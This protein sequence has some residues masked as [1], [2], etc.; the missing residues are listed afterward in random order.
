M[1]LL[2]TG[3]SGRLGHRVVDAFA[4][5]HEIVAFDCVPPKAEPP[6]KV[7]VLTGD[8]RDEPAVIDAAA[9]AEV[10]I[11]LG[12]ISGRARHIP[13]SE[14][15]AINVQGTQH[16]LEAARQAKARMVILASSLCAVGLPESVDDH[17]LDYLPLDESHPCRP[18]H[19]YDLTKRINEIQ[20]DA[21]TRMYGIPTVCL[22]FPLLGSAAEDPWLVDH[23]K[24]DPP[25]LVLV[26]FLDFSDAVAVLACVMHRHDLTH[27]VMFLHSDTAG[28]NV[29]I[30]DHVAQLSPSVPWR[31]KAPLD[32]TS[33]LIDSTYARDLLNWT[34][35]IRWQDV[36]PLD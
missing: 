30:R 35:K 34:P 9:G 3:A 19:T 21:F 25:K 11:H 17:E 2:V 23:L 28:A 10:V 7:R 27:E 36:V 24:L 33:P 18:R 15:L 16:V 5:D 4:R 12:A 32:A 14:I 13:P 22:R 8:L 20:A 26:D 6:G 1:N 29:N 31:G